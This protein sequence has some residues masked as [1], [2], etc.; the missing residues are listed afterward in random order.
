MLKKHLP[1][2]ITLLSIGSAQ[3]ATLGA[4]NCR[5]ILPTEVEVANETVTWSGPCV[6]GYAEGDGKLLRFV[7]KEQ[8]GSF[9]GRMAQGMLA[10]GY[11]KSPE[12]WQYEGQYK[13]G[14]RQ[15]TG[16]IL[17]K[18][19]IRYDGE[20]KAGKREGRGAVTYTLGGR[21]EGPWTNDEPGGFGDGKITFA[22]NQ[23]TINA[24][25]YTPPTR[26]EGEAEKF[27]LHER[28]SNS[29]YRFGHDVAYGTSVPFDK[30][31][32]QMTPQQQQQFRASYPLLHHDDVPPYPEKGTAEI[33]GWLAKAQNNVMAQGDF[34]A[35]VDIDATGRA[36]AISIYSSP[37]QQLTDVIKILLGNQ[38]FTPA[39]C[40]GKP[41][42]MRYPFNVHFGS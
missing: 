29:I 26:A 22:G 32:A 15:G 21:Y 24:A 12:G 23:R 3:A 30:G 13:R 14:L 4:D 33:F 42:A 31:Y 5:V 9:E 25:D 6:N 37:D 39:L 1:A 28:D 10:D 16:S 34:R 36:T 40:S 20:W 19:G 17:Y 41:C 2:L 8:I 38:K 35:I 7:K 11:E 27:K 18:D